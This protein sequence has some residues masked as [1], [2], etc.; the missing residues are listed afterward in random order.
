[1]INIRPSSLN[2]G[3]ITAVLPFQVIHEDTV[4]EPNKKKPSKT[5]MKEDNPDFVLSSISPKNGTELTKR[6]KVKSVTQILKAT[7]P[8]QQIKEM[9]NKEVQSR[10]D[11]Y[12]GKPKRDQ[13][14]NDEDGQSLRRNDF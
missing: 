5:K 10:G 14:R 12:K 7:I 9:M 6:G 4:K 1:M 2:E 13:S 8:T 11:L 3:P